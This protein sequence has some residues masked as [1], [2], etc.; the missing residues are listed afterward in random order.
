MTQPA[1]PIR[2]SIA[3][4][5]V[6]V[7]TGCAPL[8]AHSESRF[9]RTDPATLPASVADIPIVAVEPTGAFQNRFVIWISG[10]GGWGSMERH[11]SAL[12]ADRGVPTAGINTLRYY[13]SRRSPDEAAAAVDR[14]ARA[15]AEKWHRS[16]FELVGFSFG[17]DAGPLI[18]ARL[19]P[20]V[21]ARMSAAVFLS[22]SLRA[23]DHVSPMSWLGF[24]G[25]DGVEAAIASLTHVPVVCAHGVHDAGAACPPDDRDL[26]QVV[27]L[28]GG[29]TL[30]GDWPL[31][32]RLILR[33][34]G[35]ALSSD[36]APYTKSRL[37]PGGSD[38]GR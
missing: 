32:A 8:S 10:D 20:D 24:G 33:A 15:F 30:H 14:I 22:P 35:A 2:Q 29:H 19:S 11:T 31:V 26:L 6:A 5:L 23:A 34:P 16:Q 21:R 7:V 27:V 4:A 17:A 18:A 28:P 9:A 38:H 3:Y 13:W 12:L 36:A 25:E 37:D 1:C